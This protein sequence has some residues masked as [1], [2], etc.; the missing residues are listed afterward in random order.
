MVRNAPRLLG[1]GPADQ[2]RHQQLFETVRYEYYA[3]QIAGLRRVSRP[4]PSP[5]TRSSK[6]RGSGLQGYDFPAVTAGRPHRQGTFIPD[7]FPNGHAGL[8]HEHPARQ[9]QGP[10]RPPGAR[11][12]VRLQVDQRQHHVWRLSI[13]QTSYFQNSPMA[14]TG[15]ALARSRAEVCSSPYRAKLSPDAFRPSLSCRPRADGS[16][17][18]QR[19]CCARGS[20]CLLAAGCKRDGQNAM[21]LP[22][23]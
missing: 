8:V 15:V 20:T 2:S 16:G 17:S 18:D 7:D 9:V 21:V 3:D 12:R 1:E 10:S 22:D 14:A 4:A 6:P 19:L 23:G 5:S 11:L 13:A